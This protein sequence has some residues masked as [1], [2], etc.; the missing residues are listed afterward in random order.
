MM[1]ARLSTEGQIVRATVAGQPIPG[2]SAEAPLSRLDLGL[3]AVAGDGI[4]VTLAMAE[5]ATL[6]LQLEDHVYRLPEVE[7]LEVRPRPAW[8]MPSPT[9]VSDATL[10]RRTV[11][12]P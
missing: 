8:M 9:F 7:G 10:V 6:T 12:L 11:T 5:G 4:E 1:V 2:V 3:H